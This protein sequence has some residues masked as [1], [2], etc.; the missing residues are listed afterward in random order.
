MSFLKYAVPAALLTFVFACS[1]DSSSVEPTDTSSS[2]VESSSTE[3]DSVHVSFGEMTDSRDGRTYKTVTIGKQTWMAENLDFEVEGSFCYDNDEANCAKYGRLYIWVAAV[4]EPESK[5][6]SGHMCSLPSTVQ[7][8]CPS[9]WHLPNQ[10]EFETLFFTISGNK[11][12]YW[13]EEGNALKTTNGWPDGENGS[14]EYGFSALPAGIMEPYG[15]YDLLGEQTTF[16]TSDAY[17]DEDQASD[18]RIGT[19]SHQLSGLHLSLSFKEY[20]YSVRCV[21]D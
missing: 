19:K 1:D 17:Y 9:G 10:K 12:L 14:D 20:A 21:K 11:D 7:G 4:N 2:S 16:W 3:K 13:H 15:Y 8:V 6:G 5:C 18:A